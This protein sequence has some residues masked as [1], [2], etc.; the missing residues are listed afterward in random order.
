MDRVYASLERLRE[1]W[2]QLERGKP[3]SPEYQ[4]IANPQFGCLELA[5]LFPEKTGVLGDLPDL[6]AQLV[7]LDLDFREAGELCVEF[8]VDIFDVLVYGL[9]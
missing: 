1:L 9:N 5:D 3:G 4:E 8:A 6:L 2:K 7:N